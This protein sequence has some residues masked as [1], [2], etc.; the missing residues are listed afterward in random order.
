MEKEISILKLRI[1]VIVLIFFWTQTF[2]S[3]HQLQILLSRDLLLTHK[4]ISTGG[5]PYVLFS[6]D[7]TFWVVSCNCFHINPRW[8][9]LSLHP[10][11]VTLNRNV[12]LNTIMILKS[13]HKTREKTLI[14]IYLFSLR[15]AYC[16]KSC[17]ISFYILFGVTFCLVNPL[18]TYYFGS[19]RNY[20]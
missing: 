18:T 17:F 7:K 19:I 11:D 15:K 2:L 10:S 3:F 9:M 14:V 8:G 12:P 16:H 1:N 5:I 6:H 4:W 20:F 13:L